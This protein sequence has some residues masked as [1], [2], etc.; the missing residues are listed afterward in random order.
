MKI[1]NLVAVALLASAGLQTLQADLLVIRPGG[2][3]RTALLQFRDRN[4]RLVET[5]NA[6]TEGFYGATL[7]PDGAIYATGNTLGYGTVYRFNSSGEPL[8]RFA[9]ANLKT[10]GNLKFGPDGNLYVIGSTWPDNPAQGLVLRYDGATGAFI[11]VF[12]AVENAGGSLTDLAF[13][14]DGQLYLSDF[15]RGILRYDAATGTLVVFVPVGAAGLD[16]PSAF[17]FGPDGD[18]YVCNRN[19]NAVLKFNGRSGAPMR[20]LVPSGRGGL[21]S[22]SGIAFGKGCAY[23]SSPE[24]NRVLKYNARTGQFLDAFI[25]SHPEVVRPGRLLFLRTEAEKKP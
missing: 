5:L 8:G 21:R 24:N 19:S 20:A 2:T 12:L 3:G 9:G 17:V 6:D 7:G 11:D 25:A 23:V 18:L 13:G 4:A 10:P 14:R 15:N 22:P 1:W 16:S